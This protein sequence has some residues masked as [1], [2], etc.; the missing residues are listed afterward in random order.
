MK[1]WNK[2]LKSKAILG[3]KKL[4]KIQKF[5]PKAA[6]LISQILTRLRKLI[7][8]H[9]IFMNQKYKEEFHLL[10]VL[11]RPNNSKQLL[12]EHREPLLFKI[13]SMYNQSQHLLKI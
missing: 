8:S 5:T 6:N 3:K 4:K 12:T 13:K 7:N 2:S 10:R 1:S 11:S 9:S